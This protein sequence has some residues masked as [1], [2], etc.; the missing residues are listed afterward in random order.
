M[1]GIV[2]EYYGQ[3]EWS[4]EDDYTHIFSLYVDSKYRGFGRA[5]DLIHMTI[6]EIRRAGYNGP[7]SIVADSEVVPFEKLARFYNRLGLQVFNYYG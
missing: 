2:K 1:R 3:C 4:I 6:E 7:I 5:A